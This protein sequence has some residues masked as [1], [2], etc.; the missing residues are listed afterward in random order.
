[1]NLLPQ[2]SRALSDITK[3]AAGFLQI[4]VN[5]YCIELNIRRQHSYLFIRQH[6]KSAVRINA[7]R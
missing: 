1:M 2:S 7:G 5:I 4:T 6:I 3:E